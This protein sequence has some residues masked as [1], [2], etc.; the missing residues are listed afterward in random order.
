VVL[1]VALIFVVLDLDRPSR[2]LIQ[3]SQQSLIELQAS[4]R[5]DAAAGGGASR[6]TLEP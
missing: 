6:R 5:Q 3:V 1:I 4:M 2:G